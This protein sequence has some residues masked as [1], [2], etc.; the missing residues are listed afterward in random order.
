MHRGDERHVY[1]MLL[2][3]LGDEVYHDMLFVEVDVLQG[4]AFGQLC[5]LRVTAQ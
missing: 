4:Y 5:H 3:S 2:H 1:A